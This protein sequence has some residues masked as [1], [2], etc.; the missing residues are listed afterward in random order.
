M[1]L[2]FN[3]PQCAGC[4]LQSGCECR[5][6]LNSVPA[7]DFVDRDLSHGASPRLKEVLRDG[8][9]T[10]EVNKQAAGVASGYGRAV[11][12]W[13]NANPQRS[14]FAGTADPRFVDKQ[15]GFQRSQSLR[16]D[17]N[18]GHG[19]SPLSG[20]DRG[21]HAFDDGLT[22]TSTSQDDDVVDDQHL[23]PW[24]DRLPAYAQEMVR[25]AMR[26]DELRRINRERQGLD[27]EDEG[28]EDFYS[29]GDRR[30]FGNYDGSVRVSNS[31]LQFV[32]VEDDEALVLNGSVTP[33]HLAGNVS[34]G[35][36]QALAGSRPSQATLVENFGQGA[37]QQLVEGAEAQRTRQLLAAAAKRT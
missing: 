21:H 28:M 31:G 12:S 22:D 36:V 5:L 27:D 29:E 37:V 30:Q 23:G 11:A 26:D 35:L 4:G 15:G 34:R 6:T 8:C 18:Y 20:R 2:V 7:E 32:P 9:S 16:E 10:S 17:Y 14:G 1:P 19:R 13:D 33:L 25:E 24:F 3:N